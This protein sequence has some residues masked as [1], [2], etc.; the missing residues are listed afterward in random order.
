MLKEYYILFIEEHIMLTTM[1]FNNLDIFYIVS[2]P[3]M[4]N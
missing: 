1:P 2:E 4:R 3:V